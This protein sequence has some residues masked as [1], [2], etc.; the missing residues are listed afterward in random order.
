MVAPLPAQVRQSQLGLTM[1]SHF[2]RAVHIV[3]MSIL[4]PR[5]VPKASYVVGLPPGM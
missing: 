3:A 1:S 2:A 4:E 5:Q